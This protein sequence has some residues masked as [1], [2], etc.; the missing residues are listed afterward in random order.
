MFSAYGD[1]TPGVAVSVV[2]DGNIVFEK[3]YGLANLEY[4]TPI[5][6]ST[7]F[8]TASV[9]K[10]FTA[11]SILLLEKQG[12]LSLED[13]IRK[14]IPEVPD[15]GT[16]IT[17]RHLATHTS[18]IKDQ[19]ALLTLAGW[20]MDD[21][22][23][24]EQ[25]LKIL[26]RQRT[27]N[28]PPG[29][30]FMYSNSGFTL[31]AEVVARVSNQS[32]AEFTQKNIFEPLRMDDTQFYDDHEKIVENRAYS[33]AKVNGTYKNR[34][35]NF[36]NVGATSLFTTAA[37]LSKWALNFEDPIVGDSE[38]VRKLQEPA[39]LND[40]DPA[41][42][43]VVGGETIY[44]AMGQFVRN[45]RG[46][47][48]V[49]H[50]GRDAGFRAYLLRFPGEKFS[51][52]LLGND[53]DFDSFQTGLTIAE[54]FM[55]DKL[56]PV[57]TNEA[58]EANPIVKQRNPKAKLPGADLSQYEG[59]YQNEELSSEFFVTARRNVLFLTHF[60]LSDTILNATGKDSYSG[61]IGFPVELT[62]DRNET[63]TI[64]GFTASNFGAKNVVFRKIK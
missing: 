20:R 53:A 57:G 9:S 51:V 24:T 46:L 47:D 60:R 58:V 25:I 4:K 21:V 50:T 63:G 26:S 39:R 54:F 15:F 5:K 35:L 10:Q 62:F 12:K 64:T 59:R 45:Y 11:F 29:S 13:D 43:A 17:L 41:V 2:K 8:H 33:Y 40:G 42:L 27:L 23:T 19:W 3:G 32:F 18:G 61:T 22:I 1:D 52:I 37:D 48:I 28:F 16:K 6:P 36:A 55:K 34:R 31:L 14:Y 49:N 38:I 30:Q 7:V 44:H 56:K